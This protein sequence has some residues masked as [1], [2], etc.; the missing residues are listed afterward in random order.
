MCEC[1]DHKKENSNNW[2]RTQ[3]GPQ[4]PIWSGE[5]ESGYRQDR[6][7]AW[8]SISFSIKPL[9]CPPRPCRVSL[10]VTLFISL[11]CLQGVRGETSANN[12]DLQ[13]RGGQGLIETCV[14]VFRRPA[15]SKGS[16]FSLEP[17]LPLSG[18]LQGFI[19]YHHHPLVS[20]GVWFQGPLQIP[21]FKALGCYPAKW[22]YSW[23]SVSVGSK[24]AVGWIPGCRHGGPTVPLPLN[25]LLWPQRLCN[26][27]VSAYNILPPDSV[28]AQSHTL[29]VKHHL[30]V[31]HFLH[32][33][34][35]SPL[36]TPFPVLFFSVT[37]TTICDTV[38]FLICLLS[39]SPN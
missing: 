15:C 12:P 25:T 10:R 39:I 23:P 5:G 4:L 6:R 31:K 18:C 14:K 36:P 17:K 19:S 24:S 8:F 2:T 13:S 7:W 32:T 3:S 38:I 1:R 37:L 20:T 28:R 34:P 21:K 35:L 16:L 26:F 27:C 9:Q 11:P 30:S 29:S 22:Q 33:H